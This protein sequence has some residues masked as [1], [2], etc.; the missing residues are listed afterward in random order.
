MKCRLTIGTTAAG[1]V[2][3]TDARRL[4]L[5][6]S[7]LAHAMAVAAILILPA[8]LSRELPPMAAGWISPPVIWSNAGA[9]GAT[10]GGGGVTPIVRPRPGT[11]RIMLPQ[12]MQPLV[13]DRAGADL[14]TTAIEPPETEGGECWVNC[15]GKGKGIG[16]G[17]GSEPPKLPP[18]AS[19]RE[20]V[21]AGI[22]GIVREP[23]KV[24][25]VE[26]VYPALAR[27]VRVQGR[28]VLECTLSPE[29]VV[30][31]IAVVEGSPLLAPAAVS[32]VRE[33]RYLPTLLN[34]MPVAVQL[35]VVV[36]FRIG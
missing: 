5:P 18:A 28:V 6:L 36:E 32:A 2:T 11:P 35:S 21:R 34:G 10:G 19:A 7:A 26:P 14:D 31:E 22:G 16:D 24:K 29:G 20:P 33:W 3:L 27:S 15:T 12:T 8:M 1:T 30:E 17:T 25:H 23:R 4:T 9:S 13:A